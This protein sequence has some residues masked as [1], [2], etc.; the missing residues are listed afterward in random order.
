MG[1]EE[2]EISLSLVCSQTYSSSSYCITTRSNYIPLMVSHKNTTMDKKNTFIFFRTNASQSQYLCVID[3][4]TRSTVCYSWFYLF[5]LW[6]EMSW[7]VLLRNSEW[8]RPQTILEKLYFGSSIHNSQ[9]KETGILFGWYKRIFWEKNWEVTSVKTAN[10]PS[11]W[12]IYYQLEFNWE[13]Q[14][15]AYFLRFQGC[16][17]V[18]YDYWYNVL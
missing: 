9:L 14:T 5:K 11:C 4:E 1:E 2:G 10:G 13:A 6:P 18:I 12:P 8:E 3:L 17:I 15:A 16:I 7:M